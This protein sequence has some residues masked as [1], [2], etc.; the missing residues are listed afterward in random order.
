[1]DDPEL[2]LAELR[3][4]RLKRWHLAG[5]PITGVGDAI[6]FF[7]HTGFCLS[8]RA[9]T[10]LLPSLIE[11]IAGAKAGVPAY[12]DAAGHPLY[13]RYVEIR[14]DPRVQKLVLEA[15]LIR[16]RH[17]H[18]MRDLAVDFACLLADPPLPDRR[19]PETKLAAKRVLAAVADRGP[20]SKRALR[21]S[22]A[23][24]SASLRAPVLDRVLLD[25]E[26]RLRLYTVD[27]SEKEGQVYDL[28]ARAERSLAVRAARRSR[29]G[30]IDHLAGRYLQSALVTEPARVRE[31]LRGI[32]SPEEVRASLARLNKSGAI[33]RV[34][35]SGGEW[36]V[37]RG[38]P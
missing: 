33:A 5:N 32:A 4:E 36:L 12:A 14:R 20:Q 22:F 29:A 13:R 15:P 30:S 7:R 31:V 11:A 21:L 6:A 1:V 37:A 24:G 17:T 2:D 3:Q 18:V 34:R 35:A 10:F 9:R 8:H 16:R 28:F 19:T 26:S 23:H 25:L 38:E 27:Y